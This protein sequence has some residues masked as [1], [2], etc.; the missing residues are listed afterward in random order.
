MFRMVGL[1]KINRPKHL[2]GCYLLAYGNLRLPGIDILFRK[3][4]AAI[5]GS[6]HFCDGG[7][8]RGGAYQFGMQSGLIQAFHLPFFHHP[9]FQTANKAERAQI[10]SE[11]LIS[12][13]RGNSKITPVLPEHFALIH[14]QFR[15]G[16]PVEEGPCSPNPG[17]RFIMVRDPSGIKI[18]V[19]EHSRA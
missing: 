14:L 8:V 12:L 11:P 19:L 18:E 3:K 9:C 13:G 6:H 7:Q 10:W 5:S 16:I 2:P 1:L 17:V 15:R 4:G